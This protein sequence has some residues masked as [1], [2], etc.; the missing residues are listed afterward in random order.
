VPDCR[1]RLAIVDLAREEK[2]AQELL[3]RRGSSLAGTDAGA[4]HDTGDSELTQ[5]QAD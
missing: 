4:E 2:Q 1:C 3:S 5:E